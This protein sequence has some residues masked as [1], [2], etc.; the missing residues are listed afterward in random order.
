MAPVRKHRADKVW[1]VRLQ[2]ASDGSKV[3]LDDFLRDHSAEEFEKL[4]RLA[5]DPKPPL[6]DLVANLTRE[7]EKAERIRILGRILDEEHD[8]SEQD[9]LLKLVEKRTGLSRHAL[10]KSAQAA[11]AVLRS[12]RDGGNSQAAPPPQ[13]QVTDDGVFWQMD[14]HGPRLWLSARIDVAAKT[15]D[16]NHGNWGLLLEW[17]DAEGHRHQWAMPMES[18]AADATSVRAYLLSEGLQISSNRQ[19]RERFTE[20]LQTAA[21]DRL[22][23]CVGCIGWHVRSYVLPGRIISPEDAEEILYQTA[24]DTG[25]Y[26]N[27]CGT[28]EDWKENVGSLCSGNSRLILAVSCAFTGP[29]LSLVGAESGGVHFHG[30]SSTGKSTALVVAGSVCGGGGQAGFVQSWRATANG[31][32]AVAAAHNDAMLPLDEISQV[33][34]RDAAEIAYQ[35][36]NGQGKGRMVRSTAARKRLVW[37]LLYVSAGELTL[38]EHAASAGKRTRGG[39][40]VRLL[41]IEADAGAEMGMFEELHGSPSA[42][43]FA[44]RLKFAAQQYYGAV[45]LKYLGLL[46]RHRVTLKDIVRKWQKRIQDRVVPQD[47]TGEVRRAAE[48]F[49]LIGASGEVATRLKL[50][51]WQR[52]ESIHVAMRVFQEWL[53]NR[54]MTGPSDAAAGIR[55]VRSF[56]LKH[57]TSR[58]ENAQLVSYGSKQETIRDRAGFVRIKDRKVKE[59]YIFRDAFQ[60]EVCNGHS[61]KEVLKALEARGFLRCEPP[62]MTVKPYLPG[63]GRPRVYCVLSSILEG[64]EG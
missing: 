31:L 64:D 49:A 25:H 53:K 27:E 1:I 6:D 56:L 24:H 22:A 62:N 63:V 45:F 54:G 52:N 18:L 3:G 15:R 28:V 59:F 11:A 37:R 34:A 58:F 12:R 55:A 4:P 38:S 17:K 9:R 35:L 42:D 47:A 51:G 30:L 14:A 44:N 29:L 57:G 48:R 8:P 13:F 10:R 16:A 46:V 60:T 32:E 33:D 23:R 7:T 43:V 41:N 50:T 61:Y 26:W 36:G 20:Y 39:A 5:F 19:L 2:P 21:V 40:E